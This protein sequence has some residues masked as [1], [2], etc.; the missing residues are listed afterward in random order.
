MTHPACIIQFESRF[1]DQ[2]LTPNHPEHMYTN[3]IDFTEN[4]SHKHGRLLSE[5][6]KG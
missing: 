3:T 4:E 5:R 1:S 2:I 6:K